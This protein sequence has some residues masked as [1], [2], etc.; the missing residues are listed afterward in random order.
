MPMSSASRI[1]MFGRE[2]AVVAEMKK[3]HDKIV[4]ESSILGLKMSSYE[5]MY[6]KG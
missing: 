2:D 5:K 1:M 6:T 3:T 4:V